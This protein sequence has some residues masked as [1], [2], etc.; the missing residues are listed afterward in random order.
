[1]FPFCFYKVFLIIMNY[2]SHK[3]T[4]GKTILISTVNPDYF[5]S[6]SWQKLI[7][8][9]N[10][11]NSIMLTLC[12][13]ALFSTLIYLKFLTL[14]Q[15]QGLHNSILTRLSLKS[16]INILP[17]ATRKFL[18]AREQSDRHF[19]GLCS[20]AFPSQFVTSGNLL[21]VSITAQPLL[22]VPFYSQS[23]IR[24]PGKLN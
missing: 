16:S 13:T 11:I 5:K 22:G 20:R 19:R 3:E 9:L 10:V 7:I 2:S 15:K 8:Q 24:N 14:K 23:L 6:N 21:Y 1:M 18:K 12:C 4:K 17:K